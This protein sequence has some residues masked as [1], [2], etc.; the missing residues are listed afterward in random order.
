[1]N[2][3]LQGAQRHHH[4]IVRARELFVRFVQPE[5]AQAKR[6]LSVPIVV[7][8]ALWLVMAALLAVML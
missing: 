3:L 6:Y 7:S 1:M 4:D 8:L 2:A 5:I